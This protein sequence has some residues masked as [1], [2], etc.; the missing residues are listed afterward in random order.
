MSCQPLCDGHGNTS[1]A[2]LMMWLMAA[3][4]SLTTWWRPSWV[5]GLTC[6]SSKP[7]TGIHHMHA[8]RTNDIMHKAVLAPGPGLLTQVPAIVH[9]PSTILEA[10]LPGLN[11]MLVDRLLSIPW[12]GGRYLPCRVG[13]DR[14][15]QRV[16]VYVCVCGGFILHTW[17]D[18]IHVFAFA[19]VCAIDTCVPFKLWVICTV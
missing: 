16:C 18:A 17:F 15:S 6:W 19:H 10:L 1:F 11:S 2:C 12:L 9:D 14:Q 3:P 13:V 8:H 7:T 4:L 5:R